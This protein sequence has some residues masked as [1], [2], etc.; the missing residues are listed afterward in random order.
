MEEIIQYFR[1][2]KFAIEFFSKEEFIKIHE[3]FDKKEENR[4]PW[5]SGIVSFY[6]IINED[7]I[8]NGVTCS[9]KETYRCSKP[10]VRYPYQDYTI[11]TAEWFFTLL[12]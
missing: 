2:N 5:S 11:V 8:I 6:E 12:Y 3:L 10:K 7:K 9:S 1:E 4:M